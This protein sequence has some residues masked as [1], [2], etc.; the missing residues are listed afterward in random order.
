MNRI[1]RRRTELDRFAG[2]DSTTD[3]SNFYRGNARDRTIVHVVVAVVSFLQ[4]SY[5]RQKHSPHLRFQ[6][7]EV[8]QTMIVE[9]C[10]GISMNARSCFCAVSPRDLMIFFATILSVNCYGYFRL[11]DCD[12]D[13]IVT[14]P[15]L[16]I[17]TCGFDCGHSYFVDGHRNF[18]GSCCYDCFYYCFAFGFSARPNLKPRKS[19]RRPRTLSAILRQKFFDRAHQLR[20][21]WFCGGN[22]IRSFLTT[23]MTRVQI[24]TVVSRFP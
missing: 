12:H 24:A 2:Y 1:A 23:T 7:H 11:V 10:R 14:V 17:E 21:F 18:C 5:C 19:L 4:R 8:Y 20:P 9:F 15:A 22:E 3:S 16:M 13:P 6:L